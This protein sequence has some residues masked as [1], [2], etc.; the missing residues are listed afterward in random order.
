MYM[1]FTFF[2]ASWKTALRSGGVERAFAPHFP[3][4]RCTVPLPTPHSAATSTQGTQASHKLLRAAAQLMSF[5]TRSIKCG[6]YAEAC[7]AG[8]EPAFEARFV[9]PSDRDE[10]H[11]W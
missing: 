9:D 5:D 7:G 11:L 8:A 2:A 3:A 10:R 6:A 4:T 1:F